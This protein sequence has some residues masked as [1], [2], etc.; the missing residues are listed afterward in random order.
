MGMRV[1]LPPPAIRKPCCLWTGKQIFGLILR[2][3]RACPV[4]ASLRAKSKSYTKDLEMCANDGYV[5]IRNSEL[6]SGT[7]DKA[8]L[9]SGSKNNIFY[10]LLRLSSALLLCL[11]PPQCLQLMC[12]L[13]LLTIWLIVCASALW[14]C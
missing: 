1:E 11:I 6:L 14:R 10:I 9:G 12:L 2:P 13:T 4:L 8:T 3:S 7:M 5:H